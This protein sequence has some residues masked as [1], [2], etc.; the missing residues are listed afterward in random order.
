MSQSTLTPNPSPKG[1]AEQGAREITPSHYQ[2]VCGLALSAIVLIQMQQSI[3]LPEV[4]IVVS[5]L[6]GVVGALGIF[7]R[8][9]LSP[10]TVF[11][12]LA[13]PQIIEQLY[14]SQYYGVESPSMRFLDVADALLCVAALT[15][16][17][18]HYRLHGLWF[19]VLPA[20]PRQPADKVEKP[21]PPH[22]RSEESMTA[23][24][25]ITLVFMVPAFALL[26]EFA[27]LLLAQSWVGIDLPPR[28]KQFLAV[29]W[30]LLL[31][32]FVAAQG[33]RHWRRLQMDRV[34]AMLMLQDILWNETR[35]EQRRISRW[36]A[37][38]RLKERKKKA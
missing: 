9:R 21:K 29:A 27:F 22:V 33:F 3:L 4:A 10:L 25:L 32:L 14:A 28:W 23:A 15:Y 26:A 34:S 30:L 35:G 16:F 31:V 2:A 6:I 7:Y 36:L 1:R 24:E 11:I 8:S 20:D 18:G 13:A 17:I 12:A 38:T 5:V 37:W 19:G